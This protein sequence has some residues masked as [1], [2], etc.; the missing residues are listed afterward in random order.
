VKHGVRPM[1]GFKSFWAAQRPR[2]GIEVMHM[3]TKGQLTE[4]RAQPAARRTVLGTGSL[5]ARGAG[6]SSPT[7]NICAR[8]STL[9]SIDP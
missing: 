2:A 8:A 4:G 5:I 6:R 9:L 7:L 1:Q 3:I